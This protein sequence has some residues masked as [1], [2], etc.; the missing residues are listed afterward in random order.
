M[1]HNK[2]SLIGIVIFCQN[3]EYHTYLLAIYKK[4]IKI[5]NSSFEDVLDNLKSYFQ[6]Y[7]RA[8]FFSSIDSNDCYNISKMIKHV[9]KIEDSDR[10]N[11]N[12]D[13]EYLT[14][15]HDLALQFSI[16]VQKLLSVKN[17][18]IERKQIMEE[19][20]DLANS[21]GEK[22]V[23]KEYFSKATDLLQAILFTYSTNAIYK[24]FNMCF[25]SNCYEKIAETLTFAFSR[26]M[27]EMKTK[28]IKPGEKLYRGM[29][30][31]RASS[32]RNNNT[33]FWKAF[34]ST[35]LSLEKAEEF[36]NAL[37]DGGTIFEIRLSETKP[38][39]HMKLGP[40]W[41][42]FPLEK[43]VLIWPFFCF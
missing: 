33:A 15:S 38:H 10:F 28:K 22:N 35:S 8:Y 13:R 39:P 2:P 1:I 23:I 40:G 31:D 21:E 11:V 37:K 27:I 5:V 26:V 25:A 4:I 24:N 19:L 18:Q 43:E 16:I 12:D 34:T 6:N 20:M 32:Y 30:G 9:Y 14:V 7:L 29:K 41:S 36:T 3:I 17:N 42:Q